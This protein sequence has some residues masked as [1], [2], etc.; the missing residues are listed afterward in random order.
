MLADER[1]LIEQYF[2]DVTS[3]LDRSAI[4]AAWAERSDEWPPARLVEWLRGEA[5][6]YE[7]NAALER[8]A[9]ETNPSAAHRHLS[10]LAYYAAERDRCLSAVLMIE[11]L[12]QRVAELEAALEPITVTIKES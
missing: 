7:E 6:A 10:E 11:R 8:K 9:I 5:Q 1:K 3:D 12:H 4:R 2:N